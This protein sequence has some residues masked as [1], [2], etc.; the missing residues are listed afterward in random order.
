MWDLLGNIIQ[1]TSG[2]N[3]VL[4]KLLVSFSQEK[5]QDIWRRPNDKVWRIVRN[6]STSLVRGHLQQ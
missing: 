6:V 2:F 4:L 3:D 1:D 5:H